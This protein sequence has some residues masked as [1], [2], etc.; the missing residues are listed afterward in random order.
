MTS[1]NGRVCGVYPRL[2]NSFLSQIAAPFRFSPQ[3]TRLGNF[4]DRENI[5]W[6]ARVALNC[7][8]ERSRGD[9]SIRCRFVEKRIPAR[10]PQISEVR[11]SVFHGDIWVK[12]GLCRTVILSR[13]ADLSDSASSKIPL[14]KKHEYQSFK[15]VKQRWLARYYLIVQKGSVLIVH[16]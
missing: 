10:R 1:E 14:R 4:F 15:L 8:G 6:W 2:L 12:P 5:A 7:G 11:M 9:G 3:V 13:W 16:V